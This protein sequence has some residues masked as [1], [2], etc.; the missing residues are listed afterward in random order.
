MTTGLITP[1][2]EGQEVQLERVVLD[3][4]RESRKA[5]VLD[6]DGMQR[7]L[8]NGGKFQEGVIALLAKLSASDDRFELLNS[9]E[10]TVPQ[11]YT[12]GTQLA[13]FAAFAKNKSEKFYFYNDSITDANYAKATQKLVPGKTYGVKIFGIKQRVTSEDCLA[14]LATQRAILVGAQGVSLTRQLKRE[15]FPVEKWTVSFDEK[16]ALWEDADGDHGV[17][18]VDRD[19]DGDWSFDLGYFGRDWNDAHCLVCFCD[20]SA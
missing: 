19:S 6:K 8:G 10:L 18:L 2:T 5:V 1:T 9:F 14:F 4:V 17:P 7:L 20:L 16:D 3:T 11:K 15:Q 13:T 12:H